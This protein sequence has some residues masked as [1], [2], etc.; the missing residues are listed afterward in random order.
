MN[1]RFQEPLNQIQPSERRYRPVTLCDGPQNGFCPLAA[2]WKAGLAVADISKVCDSA[3]AS[4]AAGW[5]A[6]IV[7]WAR[8]LL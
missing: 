3:A 6:L 4:L 1:I 2:G 8:L 7:V 5:L